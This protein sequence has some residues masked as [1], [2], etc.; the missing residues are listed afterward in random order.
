MKIA[1]PSLF[2]ILF[3]FCLL[4][5]NAVASTAPGSGQDAAASTST[6]ITAV[7]MELLQAAF[8][9]NMDALASALSRGANPNVQQP[10]SGQTALMGAVLR[11][12]TD[13]V[14]FLLESSSSSS[15]SSQQE[16]RRGAPAIVLD[17]NV[18]EKDGYTP[19]HGAAFQGRADCMRVL[20][21]AGVNVVDDYH[22]DGFAPLH[23]ACWGRE[24]RHTDTIQVLRDEIGVD[25]VKLPAKNG[26]RCED[27][28]TNTATLELLRETKEKSKVGSSDEL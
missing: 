23:R 6:T 5:S 4:S 18:P 27:M 26:K 17:V 21:A 12:Y 7:D 2:L 1:T 13:I 11:G 24:Q 19:A 10:G 25:I 16:E 15:S 3:L 20:V 8:S 14:K 28:T 22:P 9:N